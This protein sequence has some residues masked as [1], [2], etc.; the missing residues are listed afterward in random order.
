LRLSGQSDHLHQ[1]R[2]AR[3]LDRCLPAPAPRQPIHITD[4][5]RAALIA[6]QQ[7]AEKCTRLS[8]ARRTQGSTSTA[9]TAVETFTE[10]SLTETNHYQN[11]IQNGSD[12]LHLAEAEHLEKANHE[13]HLWIVEKTS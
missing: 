9:R 1:E 13:T 6:S 8:A 5:E 11:I 3:C 2:R 12:A 4:A 10:E 7:E